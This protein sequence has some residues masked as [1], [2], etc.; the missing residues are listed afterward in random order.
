MNYEKIITI[1]NDILN[2]IDDKT[3][4]L[5][6]KMLRV[7]LLIEFCNAVSKLQ[8][9]QDEIKERLNNVKVS[10]LENDFETSEITILQD[11]VEKIKQIKIENGEDIW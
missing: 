5:Q 7:K 4:S 11:Y 8:K 10:K 9:M 3:V 1:S 6:E 2:S